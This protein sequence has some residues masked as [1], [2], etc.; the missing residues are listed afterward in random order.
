MIK[1]NKHRCTFF[2]T[3][4]M[5]FIFSGC[6][7]SNDE[8]ASSSDPEAIRES[9]ISELES[10]DLIGNVEA[11]AV[12]Q[13]LLAEGQAP[14]PAK[15]FII[16]NDESVEEGAREKYV[17]SP[18]YLDLPEE[19]QAKSDSEMNVLVKLRRYYMETGTYSNEG[20]AYT[21]YVQITIMDRAAGTIIHEETMIGSAPFSI[22][23]DQSAGYGYVPEYQ[24][25]EKILAYFGYA[26]E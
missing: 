20:I 13:G 24:V 8:A 7:S 5:L 1:N 15:I 23:E 25:L 22:S 9:Q 16:E 3:M 26:E 10:S 2:F 12:I 17:Y 18:H 21:R 4:T 11:Y 14:I 19:L 6:G